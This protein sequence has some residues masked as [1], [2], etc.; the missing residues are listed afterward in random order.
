MNLET[1]PELSLLLAT[2]SI[3]IMYE[4]NETVLPL[5]NTVVRQS[6]VKS[7]TRLIL[8]GHDG[9][10]YSATYSADGQ[11]IMTGSKDQTAK[12]W[13]VQT[14]TKLMTLKDHS[15]W[16]YSVVYSPKRQRADCDNW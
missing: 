16:V 5:S 8:K 9:K 11:R 1:D 13:D 6:L 2:K 7:R 3:R 12:V 15:N 4:A 10:V 14:G